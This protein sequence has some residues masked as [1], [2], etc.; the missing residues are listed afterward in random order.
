MKRTKTHLIDKIKQNWKSGLTVSLVSL[1]L[2]VSLSVASEATPTMGIITAIW[3]GFFAA[4]FGGSNYNIVGPTGALSG[5]LAV[6]ASAHGAQ[7][8]PMLAIVTGIM[9]LIAWKFDFHKLLKYIPENTIQG[10][11][12]G[13]ALTIASTQLGGALGI[14][15][16]SEVKE[17]FEKISYFFTHLHETLLPTFVIF[18]VFLTLLFVLKKLTPKFPGAITL[19]PIGILIGYMSTQGDLPFSLRTLGDVYPTIAPKLFELPDIFWSTSL[20]V[21][22]LGVALVAIIETGISA[23]IADQ[24]T[25]TTHNP[26]KEVLGV[27]ISNLV[28]GLMGGIPATAALART[29]LNVKSGANDKVSGMINSICILIISFVFLAYFK[30]IPMAIIASIL[31]Y[32]AYQLVEKEPLIHMCKHEKQELFIAMIIAAV[33]IYHDTI[34]GIGLGLAIFGVRTLLQKGRIKTHHTHI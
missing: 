10:F 28:S 18:S 8:L 26:K 15:L 22:A 11:T 25:K 30:F 24:M 27:G 1:P 21:P 5:L 7:A 31:V 19:S 9:V 34:Y 6:Y 20:I 14:K 16:P 2:S 12:V 13:V 4:A 33:C 3:A 17:Q 32:T 23:Q 29:S